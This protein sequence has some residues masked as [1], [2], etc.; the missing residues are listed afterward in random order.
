[1][2]AGFNYYR[3][4]KEDAVLVNTFK[5]KKLL[6]PV[7]TITGQHSVGDKLAKAVAGEAPSLKAVIV[8]NSGHFVSEEVPERFNA[9]VLKFLSDTSRS[10]EQAKVVAVVKDAE[11]YIKMHGREKAIVAFKQSAAQ[12]FM[13]DYKGNFYLSP[14]HPELI[15]TN[16]F[17][18]KDA[19]GAFA[20]Q[21]EIGKAKA[22]GGWL[23]PRW[24]KNPETGEYQC[25][26]AYIVPLAENY[27]MGSWYNY[28][29]NKQGTC[30][31]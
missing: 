28:A 13:G 9:E 18:Y 21:E 29:P 20:V 12:I 2:T 19:F 25:R 8:K 15:G 14:L 1:M 11:D 22:G 5:N 27:F 7:L 3:T 23:K 31:G 10:P 4:L 17:N 16:Q 6:M 26:K 24:R 30:S